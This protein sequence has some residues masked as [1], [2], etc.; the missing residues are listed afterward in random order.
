MG[1]EIRSISKKSNGHGLVRSGAAAAS[2][3]RGMQLRK[4]SGCIECHSLDPSRYPLARTTICAC[5]ECGEVFPKIESLEH[6]QAIR[7]AVSE[8]GPDDSSRNIVE[9]IFKSSWLKKNNPICKVE[10][11]LKVH[12]TKHTIQRFEDYR[13]TVKTRATNTSKKN[14]RCAADG[15]ELLRFHCAT[16]T[17]SLGARGSS[18]LCA[19]IP[20][21]GVCTIIRHGFEGSKVSGV[22]TTASSGRAHDSLGGSGTRRAMLVCRVIAGTVK[23]VAAD[24]AAVDEDGAS[25]VTAGSFD[26]VAGNG[27]MYSNLEEL[28]VFNPRAILSCFVVIYKALDS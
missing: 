15:N 26:S 7:H 24:D 22:R 28:H 18:S 11:I 4:L 8:L 21:C 3:G 9:I 19:S 5:S 13:D 6:H 12:N 16:I 2:S 1:Q 25:S 17:C 20:G 27:G 14:A 23:R 10:R